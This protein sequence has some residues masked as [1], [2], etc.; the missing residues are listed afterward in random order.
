MADG[1]T[2]M[3]FSKGPVIVAGLM[4]IP[5]AMRAEEV[6]PCWSGYVSTDDVDARRVERRDPVPAQGS[7]MSDALPVLSDSDGAM[8]L[9]LQV[10]NHGRAESRGADRALHAAAKSCMAPLRSPT[11]PESCRCRLSRR[12]FRDGKREQVSDAASWA[13]P[14]PT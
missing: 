4:A 2:C 13:R 10:E 1:G 9:A 7:R 6:P 12:P 14:C 11:G 3:M 5:E 8:F